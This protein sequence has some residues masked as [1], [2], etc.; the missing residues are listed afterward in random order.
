MVKQDTG[1]TKG[2]PAGIGL[3]IPLLYKLMASML[4][5]AAVP[6]FL[7]SIV[8]VGGTQSIIASLGLVGTIAL[9]TLITISAILVCSYYLSGLIAKPIVQLSEVANDLSRG[10][11]ADSK[12]PVNR[13]D[14]I[15]TLSRAFTKMINTYRL[16]D[17]LSQDQK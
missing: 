8:A 3:Q 4:F 7:L 17:T 5:V 2:N 9:V 16:L 6:I 12:L 1:K 11:M 14:E 13:N 10:V 15:G